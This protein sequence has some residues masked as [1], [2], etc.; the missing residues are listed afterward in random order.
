MRA[1]IARTILGA[2]HSEPQLGAI[3][4]KPHQ[5]SSIGRLEASLNE[6][7]G[8]LLCDEVGMGKTFVALAIARRYSRTLIVA[9]AALR[10]MWRDALAQAG[11]DAELITFERLSR[12]ELP[13]VTPDLVILDESHH[14]RNSRTKRYM[15]IAR[16]VRG[17]HALLLTAT[18]VHNRRADLVALMSLFL[19]SRA[20]YLSERELAQCVVRRERIDTP[21]LAEIPD[22]ASVI[23]CEVPDDP[24]LVTRLMAIP[25]P[26]PPREGESGGALINRGLVHQ[27]SSSQA[28]LR[29][30][31]SRRLAKATALMTSLQMGRYPSAGELQAW[32]FA[33]GALQ[34]GFAELLSPPADDS[35]VLLRSVSVHA[36]AIELV[37][38]DCQNA[39]SIDDAR[40]RTLAHIRIRDPGAKIVAFAQYASTVSMLYRRLGAAGGVAVLTATG[41]RVAGGKLTREDAIARFAPLANRARSPSRA[42]AIE[43]L[44]T[45]DLLSEGVNLQDAEIVVHLDVPWT[46]ARLEQRVGRVARMGSRHHEVK[47]YQ[48]RPPASAERVLGAEL[49]VSSKLDIARRLVGA[50]LV[51]PFAREIGTPPHSSS[52]PSRA[53][54][55]RAILERW[56]DGEPAN[57]FPDAHLCVGAVR[58][59]QPGFIAAGHLGGVPLLLVCLSGTLSTELTAQI[60]SCLVVSG[61]DLTVDRVDYHAALRAVRDWAEHHAASVYAGVSAQLPAGRKKLVQRIDA[62]LQCAPPHLRASRVRVASVARQ[63]AAATHGAADEDYLV[64]LG[65]SEL[66]DDEWLNAVVALAPSEQRVYPD[67]AKAFQTVALLLFRTDQS[68]ID[69][70]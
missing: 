50:S 44:L 22:V 47:V 9:P 67:R 10:A 68:P 12:S 28:A 26:L 51:L 54:Q 6:F 24:D 38:R 21:N 23:S 57:S 14:A 61:P 33:E 35:E 69:H 8:A 55:L 37:L 32:T 66:P 31:L 3:R 62:A 30:A 25:P 59:D 13:S 65:G 46:A 43:M 27:W 34:L 63:V 56:L 15:R 29:D 49:L 45:T 41:A 64:R 5:E 40:A 42:E 7:G 11:L 36:K 39:T 60:A 70:V 4:L 53:E 48:L 17:A 19:G 1:V 16:L 20:K 58:A 52:I 2:A 18:P